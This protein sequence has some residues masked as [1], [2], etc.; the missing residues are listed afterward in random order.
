MKR[1]FEILVS[2][3]LLSLAFGE[4]GPVPC[5]AKGRPSRIPSLQAERKVSCCRELLTVSRPCVPSLAVLS[6]P[7]P[8]VFLSLSLSLP[9]SGGGTLQGKVRLYPSNIG[10]D[11]DS[12]E[13]DVGHEREFRIPSLPFAGPKGTR[14]R[15]RAAILRI[16]TGTGK[17]FI[18][19]AAVQFYFAQVYFV[20]YY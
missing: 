19:I 17:V 8:S 5:P 6:G 9:S 1:F 15:D 14:E 20:F 10:F 7:I 2:S 18:N 11:F 3:L 12:L 16:Q 13:T 4:I